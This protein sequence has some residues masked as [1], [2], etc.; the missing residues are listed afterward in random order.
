MG[1][2][3]QALIEFEEQGYNSSKKG[4]RSLF[5]EPDDSDAPSPAW[6]AEFNDWLD[7]YEQSFGNQGDL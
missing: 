2:L 3:K 7:K 1:K 4:S 6:E 5:G